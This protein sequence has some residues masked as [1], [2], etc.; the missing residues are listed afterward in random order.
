[1]AVTSAVTPGAEL[2]HQA[3]VEQ[4]PQDSAGVALKLARLGFS[5]GDRKALND[6]SFSIARGEIFGL[7]GPNGGGKTTLF[8]LISTLV[9][10]QGGTIR[11]L[12]E[13]LRT[14]TRALRRRFGV[15]FQ[16]PSVD[17]KL[18]VAENLAHHGHLY[19]MRGQRLVS[20][21]T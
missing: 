6:V 19:G 5:Y 4:T 2:L 1:M 17:G 13:D 18:T 8:R 3:Q 10:Q 20:R 15:V 16:H 12:G 14:S 11:L 21:I 9:P 7:L